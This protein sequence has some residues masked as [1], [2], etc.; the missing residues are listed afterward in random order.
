MPEEQYKKYEFL[1]ILSIFII[2]FLFI[3][4]ASNTPML[5]EDEAGYVSL[6]KEFM[7]L[8]YEKSIYAIAPLASLLYVPFFTIFGPSLGLAKAIIAFFGILTIIMVYLFCKKLNPASFYGINI[9]GLASIAILLTIFYFPHFM[10]L[11]YTEIPIAFFSI[12]FV[13][14]L[15]DLKT[16]KGAVLVGIIM[17]LSFYLKSSSLIFPITIFLFSLIKY[18]LKKDKEFFKLSIISIFIFSLLM[19]PFIIRNI[20]LFN[21]PFVEGFNIFFEMPRVIEPTWASAEAAKLIS[22]PVNLFN[23]FGFVPLFF[24]IIGMIYS[25]QTKNKKII[26][27]IFLFLLFILVFYFRNILGIAIGDPR[28]LSIIFPQIAVLGGFY[29]SQVAKMKKYISLLVVVFFIYALSTSITVALSTSQSTRYPDNYIQALRWV[30]Q[31][32]NEDDL[33]FTAY[34]GSLAYYGERQNV[35]AVSMDEFPDLMHSTNSTQIYKTLKEYGISYILIWRG[36]LSDDWIIPE[37]NIIGVFT[38]NFAIQV[39]G[40][41]ENF[42]MV[43]S[44]QD[45]FIYKL[46]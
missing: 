32:T 39:D 34:S 20:I 36:I 37:S 29:I 28:Y 2:G 38:Y 45:N 22:I 40:D 26:P 1:F 15:L 30:K 7:G 44:N 6:A 12:L 46:L 41:K 31:N 43:Y 16:I 8:E 35:W 33:I 23:V 10:M 24:C 14:L 19:L 27:S 11:S 5:G 42:E 18:I 9:C 25:W 13:Y 3:Y 17:G 4:L 21:Y